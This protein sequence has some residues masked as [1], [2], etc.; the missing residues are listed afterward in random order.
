MF[1]FFQHDATPSLNDYQ[2]LQNQHQVALDR[3]AALESALA[4]NQSA[5]RDVKAGSVFQLRVC[6]EAIHSTGQSKTIRESLLF[7]R[8]TLSQGEKVATESSESG[9]FIRSA[10]EGISVDINAIGEDTQA[11]GR[12]LAVLGDRIQEVDQIA[13]VIRN[14]AEQTNLLALNAAIEAARA[15]EAGRGFAVVA[16]EVRKLAGN[17][18]SEAERVIAW[19]ASLRTDLTSSSQAMERM[20]AQSNELTEHAHTLSES[21]IG[22]LKS[23]NEMSSAMTHASSYAFFN[24]LKADHIIFK[25]EVLNAMHNADQ[26]AAVSDHR[27]CRLGKWYYGDESDLYR[28]LREFTALEKPHADFHN[29]GIACLQ[30]M[31]TGNLDLALK[32]FSMMGALSDK[33][34]LAIDKLGEIVEEQFKTGSNP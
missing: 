23:L 8:D 32:E 24:L 2:K 27:G 19:T 28:K 26:D 21:M 20:T 25:A 6:E 18:R 11:L 30:A 4:E 22:S 7:L 33:V 1:N 10:V 16:D 31:A 5:L 15:G 13:T 14:V 12:S 9:S 17:T 29:A 3:I 34:M